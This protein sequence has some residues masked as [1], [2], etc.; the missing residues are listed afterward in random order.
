M[1][2][3]TMLLDL[4]SSFPWI[5]L[6]IQSIHNL[7]SKSFFLWNLQMDPKF[8]TEIQRA[9]YNK[10]ALRQEQ[11]ERSHPTWYQDLL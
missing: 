3:Y 4:D 2:W 9:D 5:Y 7:D 1:F 8:Y 6:Y 10:D 11:D